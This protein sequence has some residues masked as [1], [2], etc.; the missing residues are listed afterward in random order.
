MSVPAP[1]VA[2]SRVVCRRS[3]SR[4]G[5]RRLA[6]TVVTAPSVIESP[7]ATMVPAPGAL[8]STSVRKGQEVMV[9]WVGSVADAVKSPGSD[10]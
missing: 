2:V 8:T 1:L 7:R 6:S 3:A 10:T 9:R 5:Q 4:S